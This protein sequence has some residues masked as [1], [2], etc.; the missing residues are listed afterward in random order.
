M[1]AA[2]ADEVEHGRRGVALLQDGSKELR[3]LREADRV[4]AGRQVRRVFNG[5]AG[6]VHL[7]LDG[8]EEPVLSILAL[9]VPD[10]QRQHSNTG[11][12]GLDVLLNSAH[13]QGVAAR[14]AH[15]VPQHHWHWGCGLRGGEAEE[16]GGDDEDEDRAGGWGG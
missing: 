12:R 3:A 11:Q 13:G 2:D 14:V 5:C 7:L 10:L 16:R 6:D 15:S 4:V 8:H 9:A 1:L